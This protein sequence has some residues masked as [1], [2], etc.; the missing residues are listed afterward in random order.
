[1][2]SSC[3]GDFGELDSLIASLNE[4]AGD[5]SELAGK[6]AAA[7][8]DLVREGFDL[9]CAPDGTPWPQSKA[10]QRRGGL[11]L[12]ET[13]ALKKNWLP[14]STPQ[15]FG[16]VN[17]LPYARIHNFGWDPTW[18]HPPPWLPARAMVP[19]TGELLSG[20]HELPPRWSERFDAVTKKWLD[21]KLPAKPAV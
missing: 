15:T 21:S 11:T 7:T 19:E 10:A 3:T 9:Q 16:V 20:T 8:V 14:E 17:D 5:K 2:P 1:M 6:L 18:S 13:E 4:I 12:V